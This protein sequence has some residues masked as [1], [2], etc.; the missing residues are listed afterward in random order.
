MG[1]L[2]K[3]GT[4][5]KPLGSKNLIY[6]HPRQFFFKIDNDNHSEFPCA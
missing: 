1:I 4:I 5:S 2:F 6:F 3:D